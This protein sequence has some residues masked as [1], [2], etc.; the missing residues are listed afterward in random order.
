M[1][2]CTYLQFPPSFNCSV[3]ASYSFVKISEKCVLLHKISLGIKCLV[4][5]IDGERVFSENVYAWLVV[6]YIILFNYIARA[7]STLMHCVYALCADNVESFCL[8]FCL[9]C[10]RIFNNWSIKGCHLRRIS[11]QSI[12]NLRIWYIHFKDSLATFEI[13]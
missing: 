3:S 10:Y 6:Y 8:C 2:F 1:V 11:T 7:I 5:N 9:R 4:L 12:H 13:N